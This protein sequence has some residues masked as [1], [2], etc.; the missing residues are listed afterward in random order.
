MGIIAALL[1]GGD[2]EEVGLQWSRNVL[3]TTK[4]PSEIG[5]HAGY[6]RGCPLLL[7]ISTNKDPGRSA[8]GNS[9]TTRRALSRVLASV[10]CESPRAERPGSQGDNTRGY[11]G[12]VIWYSEERIYPALA[13][14][15]S[16]GRPT[17]SGWG[18][19]GSPRLQILVSRS[20]TRQ[21]V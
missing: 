20:W 16:V 5:S 8:R 18:P 21:G 4:D 6:S 7:L 11:Y 14:G 1:K 15:W 19:Q 13:G 2:V 10:V 9:Q 12:T 3:L 17:L